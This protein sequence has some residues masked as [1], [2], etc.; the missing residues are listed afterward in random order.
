MS[1]LR[2]R[3]LAAI[4]PIGLVVMLGATTGAASGGVETRLDFSICP[5]V[6]STTYPQ[7]PTGLNTQGCG[8]PVLSPNDAIIPPNGNTCQL[9]GN[10][11]LG[12]FTTTQNP[13]GM[14]VASGS[15]INCAANP[16]TRGPG[17]GGAAI[18]VSV[19]QRGFC[20]TSFAI[21]ARE[22][23][24]G[25]VIF[26]IGSLPLGTYDVTVT[27]PPQTATDGYGVTTTW[28]GVQVKGALRVGAKF[29]ETDAHALVTR[30]RIG[31]L[32]QNSFAG[33]G[34]ADLVSSKSGNA[35]RLTGI[36]Y[37]ACGTID[38]AATVTYGNHGAMRGSGTFVGG[39]GNYN[40]IKGNF[41]LRGRYD[42]KTGRGHFTLTGNAT[43]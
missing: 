37:Y 43:F 1:K 39:T 16:P 6:T 41:V 24:I 15:P 9:P 14:T 28:A 33:V 32:I 30:G 31:A 23:P 29:S 2:G 12:A 22:G 8:P 36:E 13:L 38:I 17:A 27:L 11:D 3:V 18:N 10:T 34:A 7:T 35:T 19:A 26:P 21:S 42:A 5:D 40:G 20:P 4:V 25:P